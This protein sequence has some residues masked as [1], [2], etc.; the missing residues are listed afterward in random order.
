[1]A[2]DIANN[3]ASYGIDLNYNQYK[4]SGEHFIFTKYTTELDTSNFQNATNVQLPYDHNQTALTYNSTTQTFDLSMYGEIHQDAEDNQVLSFKN[5]LLLD[6]DY[7]VYPDQ[8]NIFYH[9]V[10]NN[11]D[12]YYLTNGKLEQI[13]WKKS[14]ENGITQYFDANGKQLILNRGKTYIT[15]VPSDVWGSLSIN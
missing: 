12:G 3:A 6:S 11:G 4:Q 7:S 8:G 15:Y 14:G 13:T 2:G 10:D 1:M 9:I 5:V